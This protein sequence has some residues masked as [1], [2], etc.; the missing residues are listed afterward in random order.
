MTE[1]G[2]IKTPNYIKPCKHVESGGG[3]KQTR[4]LIN[5]RSNV[6]CLPDIVTGGSGESVTQSQPE[7]AIIKYGDVM[8]KTVMSH[9]NKGSRTGG[10]IIVSFHTTYR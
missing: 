5:T 7:I 9:L 4:M 3:V 10:C 1:L 2:T 6:G 8:Q